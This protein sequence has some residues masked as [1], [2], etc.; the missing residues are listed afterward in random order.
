[1]TAAVSVVVQ[2]RAPAPAPGAEAGE[3]PESSKSGPIHDPLFFCCFVRVASLQGR[4]TFF[5]ARDALVIVSSSLISKEGEDQ[6]AKQER[7]EERRGE[8]NGEKR[9]ETAFELHCVF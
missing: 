9:G 2:P 1:M 3:K 5:C 6:C 8:G 7:R 4:E